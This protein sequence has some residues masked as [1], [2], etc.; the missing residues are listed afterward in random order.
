[1]KRSIGTATML[2]Q[3]PHTSSAKDSSRLCPTPL[4]NLT[5]SVLYTDYTCSVSATTD[6]STLIWPY[7]STNAD[8][9]FLHV[10][11]GSCYVGVL[12][13]YGNFA[14][15]AAVYPGQPHGLKGRIRGFFYP[16]IS[17]YG[18]DLFKLEK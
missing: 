16:F 12:L 4:G 13:L 1:M 7:T 2:L 18:N 17:A 3:P 11:R 6:S 15:S 9:P 8:S 10:L 5:F 14:F